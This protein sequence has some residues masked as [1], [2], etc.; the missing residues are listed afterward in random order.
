MVTRPYPP[1]D[2][3]AGADELVPSSPAPRTR[4]DALDAFAATNATNTWLKLSRPGD[5]GDTCYLGFADTTLLDFVSR[6]LDARELEDKRVGDFDPSHRIAVFTEPESESSSKTNGHGHGDSSDEEDDSYVPDMRTRWVSVVSQL[7]VLDLMVQDPDLLG[8]FPRTATME[9]L[10]LTRGVFSVAAV[11]SDFS[12]A[13]CFA[14]MHNLKVSGVAVLDRHGRFMIGSISASDVRRVTCA[15][16]LAD[17]LMSTVGE[18]LRDRVW[19]KIPGRE[20]QRHARPIF[21]ERSTTHNLLVSPFCSVALLHRTAHKAHRTMR[22]ENRPCFWRCFLPFDIF[23]D[24]TLL[25]GGPPRPLVS[26][27]PTDS[28]SAHTDTDADAGSSDRSSEDPAGDPAWR[29]RCVTV[30][31]H[32]S[33]LKAMSVMSKARTH[34][35]YV[36]DSPNSHPRGVVTLTDVMRIFAVNPDG[37]EGDT[38]LTW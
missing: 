19:S 32:S 30:T 17:A 18:F 6:G 38:G 11:T 21:R 14:L 12:V 5:D 24:V 26:N 27:L 15:N 23:G 7:D 9:S 10:G 37:A 34:R 29:S 31:P 35:V 16:D 22:A 8:T 4:R 1:E 20:N 13:G 2:I 36:A 33:L 28:S 25:P 3:E